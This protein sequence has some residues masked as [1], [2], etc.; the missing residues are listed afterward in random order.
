MH[1]LRFSSVD[2]SVKLYDFY[3]YKL[4]ILNYA[5]VSLFAC[6]CDASTNSCTYRIQIDSLV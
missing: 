5:T 2:F 3:S 1:F 6:V 4:L